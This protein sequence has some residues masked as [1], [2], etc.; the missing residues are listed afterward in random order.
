[1]AVKLLFANV[2][3]GVCKSTDTAMVGAALTKMGKKVLLV[4]MDGQGGLTEI[5]GLVPAS[6]DEDPING[7]AYQVMDVFDGKVDVQ[8]ACVKTEFGDVLP[9]SLGFMLADKKYTGPNS[10][11]LLSNALK[12]V[13]RK[14]DYII[15]DALP[16]GGIALY[17]C[18]FA[19]DYVLIPILPAKASVRG[20]SYM[21]EFIKDVKTADKTRKCEVLGFVVNRYN[22]QTKFGTKILQEISDVVVPYINAPLFNT[23]IRNGVAIDECEYEGTTVFSHKDGNTNVAKDF[24]AL[25][26]EILEKIDAKRK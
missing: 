2:K 6:R 25:T 10:F 9:N 16:G 24:E 13:E 15:I 1:M 7:V 19:C 14:Y 20:I 17:N 8:K 4:D 5:C 3:G 22:K 18:L 12:G 21:H 11:Y 26:L 23:K